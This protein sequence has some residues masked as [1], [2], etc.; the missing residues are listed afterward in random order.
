MVRIW[1]VYADVPD[2]SKERKTSISY[3]NTAEL[4]YSYSTEP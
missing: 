4:G 3:V 2:I 1:V